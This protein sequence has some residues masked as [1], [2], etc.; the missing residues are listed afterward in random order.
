MATIRSFRAVRYNTRKVDPSLVLSQPYDRIRYGLQERY[1]DRSPYNVVRI[2]RGKALPEDRPDHLRGPNV[3]TRA[4]AYYE[5]WHAEEVLVRED[6]PALY[7]YHQTF[8]LD[9]TRHTR[10]GFIAAFA[11]SPFEEGIVLP[12]ERTHAEAKVDRLRLLRA[13]QVNVG[14]I[15]MLYPDREN[16]V[17]AALD[18]AI[19]GCAPEVDATEMYEDT[20]RQ[21]LWGVRDPKVILEVVE[22]LAPKRNLI[23]ADGHHRYETALTYQGEMRD[24]CPDAPPSASFNYRMVTFVGMDDPGLVILPTHREVFDLPESRPAEILAR[25][26]E[27]FRVLPADSLDACL[28]IMRSHA[29]EHAFGFYAEGHYHVLLLRD[30]VQVERW[31][32]EPRAPAWKHLDVTIAHRIL[33]EQI[34]GLSAEAAEAGANLRY[35]RDPA[36]AVEN[37]DAGQGSLVVLLNPT[38][39][40]QV[41]ACAERGERMPQKSTDFYP[42]LVSGLTMMPVSARERL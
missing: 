25:A 37:V 26:T 9:G 35:H 5:L 41:Q 7:V 20:V 21:Q 23:I 15:F 31:I 1:Y 3:Y 17:A 18:A 11:L 6:E 27:A 29:R 40:D 22:E 4:R 32:P 28:S 13:L 33:L 8:D 39:I 36:L 16:R 2:I 14:Q 24:R 19:E 34:V 12:H 42:K 30:S 10:K 38:R